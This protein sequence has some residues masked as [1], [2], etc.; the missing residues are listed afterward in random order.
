MS[1][2]PPNPPVGRTPPGAPN[3]P[4]IRRRRPKP[5]DPLVRPK[6]KP[7]PPPSQSATSSLNGKPLPPP[8]P[9]PLPRAQS[10]PRAQTNVIPDANDPTVNGFSGPLLSDT[11]V[12]YPLVTTKRAWREGLKF[13]VAKFASKK[14]IDPRDETQFTRPLRL[15][16]R[17]PRAA[18]NVQTAVKEENGQRPGRASMLTEAEREELEAKKLARAKEREENLAQIAPSV[19]SGGQ[20]RTNTIKQKTQ[21]VFKAEMTPEEISRARIRYEEALPWHLEDFDNKNIWVGSYE[22]AMSGTYAMFVL[23]ETGKMRMVPLDKW[24]KFTAKNPFRTLTIEEAEKVMARRAKDPRWVT[25]KE[26]AKAQERELA[27]YAQQ[28]R[29]FTGR[30]ATIAGGNIEGDELDYEEDRFADDEEH[31]GLEEDEEAQLAEKRI[32]RDQLKANV[33]DLRDERDYEEEERRERMEKEALKNY[34]KRVRRALQR[35]E[36]NYDYSSDSDDDPWSS[37]E[38]SDFSETEEQRR[39]DEEAKSKDKHKES[40][41][42]SRGTATPSDRPKHTDPL[43]KAPAAA[44]KRPGS[45]NLSDASGTDTSRKKPK[46]KHSATVPSQPTPRPMSPAPG[47]P[48]P[49]AEA[50]KPAKKRARNGAGSASDGER[51]GSGAEMSDSGAGA[52][53]PKKLKLNMKG[54]PTGSRAGSPVSGAPPSG[55]RASSPDAAAGGAATA[56]RGRARP[57]TP[58]GSPPASQGSTLPFPTAAEIHAAIPPTGIAS[59]ELIKLFRDRMGGDLQRFVSIVKD[60]GVFSKEDKLLRPAVL[61]KE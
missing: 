18:F 44:R 14:S 41:A 27:Q 12:D 50:S 7:I 19:S 55:S 57:S 17:D 8:P 38:S 39:A 21:Q 26:E 47:G 6:K 30:V 9:Q 20:K 45:P 35:R 49:R 52:A 43:K 36:K 54:S 10:A 37:E 32:R 33:F 23:E 11:Y 16:R 22:A 25:D 15:Q 2:T 59:S 31:V 46:N 1:A 28:R 53:V 4:A 48:G 5:A 56:G 3:G 61:K 58:R 51:A 34:G 13:H 40:G 29:L 42:S 24:Y 60:V